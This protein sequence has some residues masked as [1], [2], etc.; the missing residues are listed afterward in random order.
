MTTNI[1]LNKFLID[2]QSTPVT[3]LF[4]Q[5]KEYEVFV[6]IEN[7]DGSVCVPY[8]RD[9][10]AL[11]A[12][13]HDTVQCLLDAHMAQSGRSDL[14]ATMW[15]DKEGSHFDGQPTIPHS[16]TIESVKNRLTPFEYKNIQDWSA[17]FKK[18]PILL[19]IQEIWDTLEKQ[20]L[21]KC[22]ITFPAKNLLERKITIVQN[23]LDHLQTKTTLSIYEHLLMHRWKK[24]YE[25]IKEK[26]DSER[27]LERQRTKK[28]IL[29]KIES[30][31]E[32]Y[33][34]NQLHLL[35]IKQIQS[36]FN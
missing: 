11:A 19:T 16:Y 13:I 35:R 12:V 2:S 30:T 34:A 20:I 1:D 17:N 28:I 7:S 4:H 18:N 5:G 21:N 33:L 24:H 31:F 15:I 3:S 27:N 6:M 22:I 8:A 25:I 14:E 29:S 9:C 26:Y 10:G 36:L 32:K 23:V